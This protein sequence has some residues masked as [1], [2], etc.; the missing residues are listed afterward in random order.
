[1]LILNF[2]QELKIYHRFS[3]EF[4]G[5]SNGDSFKALKLQGV[6][7][8]MFPFKIATNHFTKY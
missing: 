2:E 5:E 1:M 8:M 4:H 6:H 3:F 7:E